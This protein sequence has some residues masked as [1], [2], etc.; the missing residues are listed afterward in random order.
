MNWRSACECT[1]C[2]QQRTRNALCAAVN[3]WTICS[4]YRW[5]CKSW[6]KIRRT[7]LSDIFKSWEYRRTDR[8]GLL[9]KAVLT[10]WIF[11]GDLT[12]FRWVRALTCT[13]PVS[14]QWRTYLPIIFTY[15]TLE[16]HWSCY[17][18]QMKTAVYV[19][20]LIQ[21]Q[22]MTSSKPKSWIVHFPCC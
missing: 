4:L 8:S 18:T 11:S 17:L 10:R 16:L 15:L 14:R 7:L 12:V 20:I 6:C 1:I 22:H 5:K 3:S 13:E 21:L 2:W 9:S 19:S